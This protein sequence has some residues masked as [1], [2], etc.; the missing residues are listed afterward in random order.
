V[1]PDGI[2][3]GDRRQGTNSWEEQFF[4]NVAMF[5]EFGLDKT[6]ARRLVDGFVIRARHTPPLPASHALDNPSLLSKVCLLSEADPEGRAFMLRLLA[7]IMTQ[8]EVWGGENLHSLAGLV[9]KVPIT[10]V[11]NH[12][13][14]LDAPAIF[15]ALWNATHP[16]PDLA[17]RLLFL[18]GLFVSRAQFARVGL[19]L[20]SSLL[21]CSPRDIDERHEL[22]HLMARINHRAFRE[23]R[24][25]QAAG[26]VLAFFPE[27]TRSP[28][29]QRQPFLGSLYRYLAETIVIPIRLD[30]LHGLLPNSGLVLQ[31]ASASVNIGRPVIVGDVPNVSAA[32]PDFLQRIA[33]VGKERTRQSVMDDLAK[34][35]AHALPVP[36]PCPA[37]E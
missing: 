26:R 12:I 20:F 23:A 1:Q 10:L 28:D 9:G 22:R 31:K 14:H 5:E 15:W 21:V 35:V 27:G 32:I 13:S 18:V 30:N 11:S 2:G 6:S 29:G 7:P 19:S 8:V 34:C 33:G 4:R 37:E 3:Q 16:G 36:P 25:L 17:E 24:G